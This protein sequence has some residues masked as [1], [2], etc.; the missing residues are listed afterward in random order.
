MEHLLPSSNTVARALTHVAKLERGHDYDVTLP[1]ALAIGGCVLSDEVKLS[2]GQ[3]FRDASLHC[4]VFEPSSS[5]NIEITLLLSPELLSRLMALFSE[6]TE[7]CQIP[8]LRLFEL[9][10]ILP[11]GV[12]LALR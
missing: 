12:T 9:L 10:W 2:I 8:A 3:K 5:N 11:W 4:F 6:D 7:A 1:A